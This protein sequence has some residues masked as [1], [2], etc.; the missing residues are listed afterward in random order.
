M[1]QNMIC[2]LTFCVC[3]FIFVFFMFTCSYYIF[4]REKAD[5]KNVKLIWQ[6][7][8]LYQHE[9]TTRSGLCS[10]RLF[11]HV[12][13]LSTVLRDYMFSWLKKTKEISS[14]RYGKWRKEKIGSEEKNLQLFLLIFSIESWNV[15]HQKRRLGRH[16]CS[17]ITSFSDSWGTTVLDFHVMWMSE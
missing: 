16:G 1:L 13:S 3:Y 11:I 4:S 15:K 10:N 9:L 12:F 7:V 17:C 2:F 8:L 6:G 14:T 5:V